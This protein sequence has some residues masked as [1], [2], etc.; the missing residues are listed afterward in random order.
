L[1][2]SFKQILNYEDLHALIEEVVCEILND[3]F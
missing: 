1:T 3:N 2:M